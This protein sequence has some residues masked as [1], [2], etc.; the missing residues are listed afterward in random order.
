M[1][2]P[3]LALPPIPLTVTRIVIQQRHRHR[4]TATATPRH[5]SDARALPWP[6]VR[7]LPPDA[8]LGRVR[9]AVG[10]DQHVWQDDWGDGGADGHD[11][12]RAAHRGHR[13]A[14]RRRVEQ[15]PQGAALRVGVA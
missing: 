9:R 12:A 6:I 15:E 3:V 8:H 13:H 2:T 7:V 11:R 5:A 1:L 14:F 10:T 4:A